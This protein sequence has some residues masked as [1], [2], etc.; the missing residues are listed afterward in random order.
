MARSL[1]TSVS[2]FAL[3]AALGL[4]AGNATAQDSLTV[5][6]WGGAYGAA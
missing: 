6:S 5:V 2:T 3:V 4:T 1:T